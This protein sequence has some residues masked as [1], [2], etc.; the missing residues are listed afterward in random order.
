MIQ[1]LDVLYDSE[2]EQI[3]SPDCVC[4]DEVV[5]VIMI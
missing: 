5:I 1:I 4:E 3:I 2:G